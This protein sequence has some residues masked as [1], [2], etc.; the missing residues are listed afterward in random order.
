MYQLKVI[1]H[2]MW[3]NLKANGTHTWCTSIKSE[4]THNI[5]KAKSDNT[6]DVYQLKVITHIMWINLKANGTHTWCASI[7]SEQTH[8]IYKAKSEHTNTC[9]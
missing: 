2:I 9:V 3:I 8:N 6:I 7:K 1:T 5:Y 4:Q